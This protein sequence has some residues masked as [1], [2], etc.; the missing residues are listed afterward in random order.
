MLPMK[1]YVLSLK[2]NNNTTLVFLLSNCLQVL[3]IFYANLFLSRFME[4]RHSIFKH[5]Q[6]E[7]L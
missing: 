3:T 2:E 4:N 1:E 7:F 6:L 5:N